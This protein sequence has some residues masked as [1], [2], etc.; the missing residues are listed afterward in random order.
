M[1]IRVKIE[2]N[3]GSRCHKVKKGKGSYTRKNKHKKDCQD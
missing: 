3:T 2:W 1:K